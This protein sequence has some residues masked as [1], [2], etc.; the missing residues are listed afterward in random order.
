MLEF[1]DI[2]FAN[3]QQISY[4]DIEISEGEGVLKSYEDAELHG[5]DEADDNIILL[6]AVV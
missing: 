6:V 4:D 2:T 3:E 1:F 5:M